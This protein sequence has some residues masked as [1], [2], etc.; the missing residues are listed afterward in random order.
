MK[1]LLCS[2]LACIAL[3][4]TAQE[5]EQ[6]FYYLKI[7]SNNCELYCFINGFPVY[8]V[9]SHGQMA[10]QI[11]INLT[12]IGKGNRLSVKA[13]PIGSN[14]SFHGSIAT[15]KGNEV[16]STDDKK[17]GALSF[18][19]DISEEADL[20]YNF[21][22][23]RFDF[24]K[25]LLESPVMEDSSRLIDYAMKLKAWVNNNDTDALLNQMSPKINDYAAA[26][27]VSSD[28]IK[29]SMKQSFNSDIFKIEW[30][31]DK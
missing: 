3:A 16:V 9:V 5:E 12:L 29:E 27:S 10:N 28:L 25:V 11:P 20:T 21:D 17:A 18:K 7:T 13:K 26:Y 4:A 19:S 23:K 2:I 30:E 31:E 8:D 15:Y 24:S 22:N 6:Q 14:A 1:V